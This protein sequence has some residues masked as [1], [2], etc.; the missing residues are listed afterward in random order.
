VTAIQTRY[1]RAAQAVAG[2]LVLGI[3]VLDA[4]APPGIVVPV[5]SPSR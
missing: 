4:K 2:G 3:F 5:L 1:P